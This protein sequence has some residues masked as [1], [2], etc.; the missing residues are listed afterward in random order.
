M[1]A[2]LREERGAGHEDV[3]RIPDLAVFVRHRV[4][5]IGAHDRA[6]R[7]VGALVRADRVGLEL[8][9][10]V[11]VLAPMFSRISAILGERYRTRL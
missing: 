7:G 11:D 3:W 6:A 8:L 1:P 10:G 4:A 9:L 2:I 5:R